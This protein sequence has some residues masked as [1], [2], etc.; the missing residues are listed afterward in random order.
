MVTELDIRYKI[1]EKSIAMILGGGR[2]SRLFPLTKA[3]AKPA[4]SVG[5]KYRLIDIPI[6]NCIN[7]GLGKIYVLTQYL[8]AGLNRHITTTYRFDSFSNRFVEVF[9]AEQTPTNTGYTQGTADAVRR[10]FR[11]LEDVDAEYIFILPGDQLCR[12]DL[13]DLLYYHI[14]KQAQVTLSCIRIRESDV[15]KSGVVRVDGN[16]R[17]TDFTEKPTDPAVVEKYRIPDAANKG[18]EFL[19]SMGVYLFNKNVLMDVL[20]RMPEHDFG[21]GI[22][23]KAIRTN[24]IHAFIFDGYW[25]DIGTIKSYFDASMMLV[26]ENPPFS[27]YDFKF[28]I[29]THQRHLP[30]A[31]IF[32][33]RIDQ[34]LISEGSII[35]RST[36]R[37]SIIGIRTY[38]RDGCTLEE[39][40]IVGNDEYPRNFV[41]MSQEERDRMDFGIKSGTTIKRAIIDKNV[42]I[43]RGSV[44]VGSNDETIEYGESEDSPFHIINGIVV[45]PRCTTLPD[46]TVI[47]ADDYAKVSVAT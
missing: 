33:S 8:S 2:G 41:K 24:T 18:K 1:S 46:H 22:F 30:S 28:P 14:Q 31:R 19:G 21:K 32:D 45:V 10:T 36:V 38:V 35:R 7:S 9:A 23:P 13:N 43:G 26:E 34:A 27:L 47:R 37:K 29:Y 16:F 39:S 3:R 4:V 11:Y 12:I 25:E 44:I 17:I 42:S 5:G 6:S 20:K 40:V 15:R